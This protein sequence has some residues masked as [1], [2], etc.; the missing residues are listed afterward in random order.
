MD[1]GHPQ[2]GPAADAAVP[3]PNET[4]RLCDPETDSRFVTSDQARAINDEYE[5]ARPYIESMLALNEEAVAAR[6]VAA[7]LQDQL[8]AARADRQ[9]LVERVARAESRVRELEAQTVAATPQN[10][11]TETS[12]RARPNTLAFTGA[13]FAAALAGIDRQKLTAVAESFRRA[14]AIRDAAAESL[15]RRQVAMQAAFTSF[16]PVSLASELG[17]ASLARPLAPEPKPKQP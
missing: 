6:G 17:E 1:M 9:S 5:I 14:A 7:A 4:L 2:S 16:R 11:P 15:K 12:T 3:N 10:G 8:K 13:S